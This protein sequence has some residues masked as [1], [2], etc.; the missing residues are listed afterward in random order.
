MSKEF[1]SFRLF[2]GAVLASAL[3]GACGASQPTP[4]L[5]DARRTYDQASRGK[6]AELV[7]D[8]LLEAKQALEQAERYHED[9]P[10]SFGEKSLAYIA[11]RKA[12]L[13]MAYA[14]MAESQRDFAAADAQYKAAQD[15]M[16]RSAQKDA[17]ATRRRLEETKKQLEQVRTD[18]KST[19]S[20]LG[21]KSKALQDR[22]RA[23]A[24]QAA[25]LEA[26]QREL[27]K[28][29]AARIEAEKRAAAA[30]ASLAEVAKIKEESRGM[31]IT[32]EGSVLFASGKW[33]LLP[34]A[35]NKLDK[36]AEVLQEQDDSKKIVVEGHTDSVG[37]D[38]KN[39]ELSQKRADA[40]R[41]HLVS[42]GV[43]SDRISAVGKGESQPV[44]DNK[45]PEGRANNRRVEIVIK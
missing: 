30:M 24:A 28:E 25:E 8:K 5:V 42:R 37:S 18:L 31:V 2:A 4:E 10:G 20:E 34:I 33:E 36:V 41:Q 32:L 15:Q 6:A 45:S 19:G 29:K 22:E 43:K 17:E 7:P 26:R 13:A 3:V 16:R 21:E 40:V 12:M 9:E 1:N 39:L 11:Q 14:G 38:Q 44:A 35:R 27:D 23:L